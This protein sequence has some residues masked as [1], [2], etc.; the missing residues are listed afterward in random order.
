MKTHP[1]LKSGAT[2]LYIC[3]RLLKKFVSNLPGPSFGRLLIQAL[4]LFRALSLIFLSLFASF[5]AKCSSAPPAA[6]LV[7]MEHVLLKRI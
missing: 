7:Y 2:F 5:L 1:Y 3:S 6:M 4:S